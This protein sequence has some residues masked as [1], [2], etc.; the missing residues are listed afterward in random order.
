MQI[1]PKF[2]HNQEYKIC[3]N[4]DEHINLGIIENFN[5]HKSDIIPKNIN[6]YPTK[7]GEFNNLLNE[8]SQYVNC[9]VN[10]I[11]ITAG[12]GKGLDLILH[13]FVVAGTKIL[14]PVP[15]YPG[16]I[17]SAEISNGDIIFINDF[18]GNDKDFIRLNEQI[19]DANIIYF[20]TPNL[21][22]G[23]VIKKSHIIESIKKYPTK[24]FI[25]DEAYYEYGGEES[26]SNLVNDY[27][28][29]IVTRTFSKTFALAGARIGYIIS[30]KDNINILRIG[31]NDKDIIDSSIKYALNVL[32]N[33]QYY[34]NN[35]VNDTLATYYIDKQLSK[36]VKDNSQIYDYSIPTA[37]WFLIKAKDTKLVCEIMKERGYLVRDKSQD[38]PNCIRISLCTI[39]HIDN[40]LDIISDI[41]KNTTLHNIKPTIKTLFLD[42]DGTLRQNYT[43]KIPEKIQNVLNK[44]KDT[45]EIKIITDN[46]ENI[47]DISQHLKESN[48]DFNIISPICKKMNP[49][50][51]DWFIYKKCVYVIKFPNISYELISAVKLFK[52]IKVIEM[53]EFI[54]SA[55]LGISPNI[56]LPHIGK[57]YMLINSLVD[58]KLQFTLIGKQTLHVNIKNGIVIGD[59]LNDEVFAKNN[60]FPFY[61]V[62]STDD[63][64]NILKKLLNE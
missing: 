40:V 18:Y 24:L 19:P 64:Y 39:K 27:K 58:T 55:E 11:L 49:N 60:E 13:A 52:K 37:P 43:E 31:Y 54:N 53:D 42:L 36:I 28:N 50:K 57:F 61:K 3:S 29:V 17:H 45:Y 26:Y 20:S 51:R 21:P 4:S 38:I 56:R 62:K 10:N 47:E 5:A 6:F 32:Q 33:K 46:F 1:N 48:I 35:V 23:Y 7:G 59:S 15:N 8:I 14:L 9:N 22:I 30:H 16:F 44:L 12:S 2:V 34:L 41:N 63:T 25:F